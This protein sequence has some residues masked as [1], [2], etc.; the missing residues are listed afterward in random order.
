MACSA[1]VMAKTIGVG[2]CPAIAADGIGVPRGPENEPNGGVF[3]G[4]SRSG[5]KNRALS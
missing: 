5:T 3:R 4:I 2:V 1:A